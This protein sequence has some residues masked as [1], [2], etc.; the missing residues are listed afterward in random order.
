MSVVYTNKQDIPIALAVWLASDNYDG[1][2][3]NVKTISAT[4]LLK[5]VRQIVLAM[6]QKTNNMVTEIDILDLVRSRLGTATHDSLEKAWVN[7]SNLKK[8]LRLLGYTP[9]VIERVVVNPTTLTNNCIPV[10]VEQ[11]TTKEVN[12]WTISGKFDLVINH[13]VQD[14]KTTSTYSWIK[15]NNDAKH[16]L[17]GSIYRWLNPNIIKSSS[18]V[19]HY[20]FTDW[21][22]VEAYKMNY[23]PIM[24]MP[25]EIELITL[26]N[27]EEF[28]KDKIKLIE[29]NLNTPESELPYCTD[30]D[31]WRDAPVFKYYKKGFV[32]A[33]STRTFDTMAEAQQLRQSDG[34]VGLVVEVKGKAKACKWCS[35]AALCTQRLAIQ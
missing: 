1:Y 9:D 2:S 25:K 21:S 24:V 27:T 10:Y 28:I 15:G 18:I 35:A 32:S 16:A 17:Q 6:R 30:E 11:R 12:G 7:P 8:A 23:P 4:T 29:D 13:Q 20:I 34:S 22:A 26:A 31:L 5:S 3:S 19:I 33:K 14:L